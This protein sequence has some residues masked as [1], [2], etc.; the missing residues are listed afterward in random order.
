MAMAPCHARAALQRSWLSDHCRALRRETEASKPGPGRNVVGRWGGQ[1]RWGFLKN[2]SSGNANVFPISVCI[3]APKLEVHWHF[4]NYGFL[5]ILIPFDPLSSAFDEFSMTLHRDFRL[6]ID[7]VSISP[8][9]YLYL[10]GP[11]SMST[12]VDLSTSL[13][14]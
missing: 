6:I 11:P 14:P 13:C 2:H 5:K 10:S 9:L 3:S 8:H 4:Q 12:P 7:Y 1:R